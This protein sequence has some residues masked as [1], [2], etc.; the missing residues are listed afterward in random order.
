MPPPEL[1][2]CIA[3]IR[4]PNRK[5]HRFDQLVV[6]AIGGHDAGEK[7]FGGDPA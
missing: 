6:V 5:A 4:R 3:G 1:A 2:K 7:A